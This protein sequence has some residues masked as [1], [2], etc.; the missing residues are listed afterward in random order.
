MTILINFIVSTELSTCRTLYTFVLATECT[1]KQSVVIT[2]NKILIINSCI[3]SKAVGKKFN[4][5]KIK[6]NG[7][8]VEKNRFT[9]ILWV[10]LLQ[11]QALLRQH[12]YIAFLNLFELSLVDRR[13][14]VL[15]LKI[16]SLTDTEL[17]VLIASLDWLQVFLNLYCV[18]LYFTACGLKVTLILNQGEGC[19]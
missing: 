18:Y 4:Y 17:N 13:T 8:N 10:N 5:R 6:S 16:F 9:V 12:I 14:E 1:H 7:W 11:Q 2:C 15:Y 19:N 3:T